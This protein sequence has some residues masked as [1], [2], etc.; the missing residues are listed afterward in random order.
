MLS[1]IA[2]NIWTI[3]ICAVLIG[4]V[5]AEIVS[6]VKKKKKGASVSCG[7]GC[8]SCPMSAACHSSK[9]GAQDTE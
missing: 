7:C 4:M 2:D 1:W 9:N 8:G 5:A 6:M 3:I